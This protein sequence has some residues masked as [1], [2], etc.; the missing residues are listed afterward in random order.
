[1]F[2]RFDLRGKKNKKTSNSKP[3]DRRFISEDKGCYEVRYATEKQRSIPEVIDY[4]KQ[5]LG[6]KIDGN[7]NSPEGQ[8]RR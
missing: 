6:F 2:R 8:R 5:K 1:M 3:Q 4:S 7:R